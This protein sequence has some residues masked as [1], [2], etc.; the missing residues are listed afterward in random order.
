MRLPQELRDAIQQQTEGLDRT[1]LARASAEL[2]RHYKTAGVKLPALA[3]AAQ[4]A[5]YLAVRLPATYAAN[6]RVLS[7]LR[8][9]APES[10]IISVLDLGSGPGTSLFAAAEVFPSIQQATAIE[11]DAAL[12]GIARKFAAQSAFP[13][14]AGWVQQDLRSGLACVAHDLVVISYALGE[15][16]SSAAATL[17]RQAWNCARQFL[18]IIEPGTT[19][20]FG[21]ITVARSLLIALDAHI[22]APCP[23][24]AACP[25][26]STDD[27]CH[28]AQRLERTAQHRQLKGGALGYEDEKFSY[29]VACRQNL[30]PA[31]AR[32]LRHPQKRGGHVELTLCSPGGIES[33]TVARSQKQDYK[34]ARRAE[35]GDAW[36]PEKSERS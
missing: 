2:T 30:A 31:G 19:P 1:A 6:W 10:N 11:N 4:R 32:I 14:N 26:A 29:V 7:E 28:F 35:W 16:P 18:V 36:E 5:A 3:T 17:V 34:S 23:H 12:I 9:L 33:R 13:G 24:A 15:L 25:L 27:W 21:V 20:G 22:L 8:K